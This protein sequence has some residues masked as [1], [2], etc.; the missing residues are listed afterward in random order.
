M[1]LK[2][3]VRINKIQRL[4]YCTKITL[5]NKIYSST[6]LLPKTDF[7]LKLENDKLIDRDKNIYTVSKITELL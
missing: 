2:H 1:I 5:N 6:V 4:K 7:P 3:S